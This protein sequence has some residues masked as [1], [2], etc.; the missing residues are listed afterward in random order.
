MMIATLFYIVALVEL[1]KRQNTIVNLGTGQ[2]KTLIAL[3]LIKH[4]ASAYQ[5]GKQTLFI[6]PSIALAGQHTTTLLANLPYTVATACHSSTRSTANKEKLAQ[7]NIL[8]ATH[9]AAKD[10]FMHY[11]DLFSFERINL[12]I[13]DECHYC[14]GEHGY[15][16]LMKNFYHKVSVEKRPRVLGLTASPLVNVKIDIDDER[17]GQML[18][19][20]ESV[21]DCQLACLSRIGVANSKGEISHRT[22]FVKKEAEERSILYQDPNPHEVP[23]LPSYEN[24]G[25]HPTRFKELNQVSQLYFQLGP[26]VTSIYSATVARELSRNRFEEETHEEFIR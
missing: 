7:A 26:K 8:V 17:L 3:L 6:V 16:T 5:E 11:G 2:G 13:V 14:S 4:F 20:L 1:A 23:M 18:D 19:N 25:L 22:G 24:K 9:G 21:M 10:L 15:T 12:L